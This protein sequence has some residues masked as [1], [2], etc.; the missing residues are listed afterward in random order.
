MWWPELVLKIFHNVKC[1]Q[2]FCRVKEAGWGGRIITAV[3]S[4]IAGAFGHL[5]VTPGGDSMSHHALFLH[6]WMQ[7]W[8]RELERETTQFALHS[9]TFSPSVRSLNYSKCVLVLKSDYTSL[10]HIW[11]FTATQEVWWLFVQLLFFYLPLSSFTRHV[12]CHMVSGF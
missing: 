5:K 4:V 1:N 7:I 11:G 3:V 8:A 2:V 6:F 10:S 9:F 12:K